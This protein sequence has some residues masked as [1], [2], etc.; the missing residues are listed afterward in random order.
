[1]IVARQG[2]AANGG[3]G[4]KAAGDM[5]AMRDV[6]MGM[7]YNILLLALVFVVLKTFQLV[8]DFAYTTYKSL[9]I[10]RNWAHAFNPGLG[11]R[12][13]RGLYGDMMYFIAGIVVAL[14]ADAIRA[15]IA[16]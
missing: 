6:S 14:N 3:S 12:L 11:Y 15:L 2:Q 7:L 8:F 10:H 5:P 9:T 1:M 16:G 4:G 13:K